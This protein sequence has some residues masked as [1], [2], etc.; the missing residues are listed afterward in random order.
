MQTHINQEK[1]KQKQL[2]KDQLDHYTN[3]Q[4]LQTDESIFIIYFNLILGYNIFVILVE[5]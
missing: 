2:K 3:F 5:F 1:S 4:A